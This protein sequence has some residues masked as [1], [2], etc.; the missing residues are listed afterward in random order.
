MRIGLS[1]IFLPRSHSSCAHLF[2]VFSLASMWSRFLCVLLTRFSMWLFLLCSFLAYMRAFR[3]K[4]LSS[5]AHFIIVLAVLEKLAME[6]WEKEAEKTNPAIE[7]RPTVFSGLAW[8]LHCTST[9]TASR[10]HCMR[11]G[12]KS[13]LRIHSELSM[14]QHDRYQSTFER[15]RNEFLILSLHPWPIWTDYSSYHSAS[16]SFDDF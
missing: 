16:V 3:L 15:R 6:I 12:A 9:L 11:V 7:M 8:S 1:L 13:P 5:F 4:A 14:L 10:W 2:S